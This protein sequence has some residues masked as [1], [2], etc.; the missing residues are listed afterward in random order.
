M[1]FWIFYIKVDFNRM[2]KPSDCTVI[3][4]IKFAVLLQILSI[5]K[6]N[7]IK[8]TNQSNER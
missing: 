8:D 4:Q 3:G 6:R 5:S 7:V 2:T 1:R